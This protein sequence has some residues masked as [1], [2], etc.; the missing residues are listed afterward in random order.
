MVLSSFPKRKTNETSVYRRVPCSL[1]TPGPY[2]RR[3]NLLPVHPVYFR[4]QMVRV[5][6]S[7]EGVLSAEVCT[8]E[9]PAI[10][11]DA[12]QGDELQHS[13][14]MGEVHVGEGL[15]LGVGPH[16]TVEEERSY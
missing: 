3:L 14:Q 2:I 9:E 6:G 16:C 11:E 15:V 4:C 8:G 13:A 10:V 7:P 5:E 1:S 12:Q